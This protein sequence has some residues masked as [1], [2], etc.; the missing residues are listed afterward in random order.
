MKVMQVIPEFFVK[1]LTNFAK[2]IFY[3]HF[4]RSFDLASLYF[5]TGIPLFLF[6][7]SYGLYRWIDCARKGTTATAG[8]VMLAGLPFLL[9]IQFFLSFFHHDMQDIPRQPINTRL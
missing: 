3:V 2:R 8:T 6:G 9:G 5:L 7:L 1:H 4:L